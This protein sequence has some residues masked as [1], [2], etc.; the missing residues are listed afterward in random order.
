M[1]RAAVWFR[2]DLRL[3]HN[4]A[5]ARA[6]SEHDEVVAVFVLDEVLLGSAGSIKRDQL[7]AHLAGLNDALEGGLSLC[8][9]ARARRLFESVDAVHLN[10]DV[11]P[12]GARRDREMLHGLTT[13]VE[14]QFGALVQPPGAVLTQ[15]GTI[16]QVFT[17]FYKQWNR[18]PVPEMPAAGAARLA[19][20]D[21]T[22]AMPAASAPPRQPG[23]PGA[24]L[25][26]LLAW[27]ECVDDYPDTRDIPSI[28][29]TSDLSADLH[30]GTLGPTQILD[31]IDA[32]TPGREGF[33]RQ[34]AWR[35]WYAH[36]LHEHPHMVDRALKPQYD[37]IVWRD[38]DEAFAAWKAGL[39]GYPIVDAGMRQLA[40]TGWMH[41]RVRMIV[42][43]FLVKHLL[44]DWRRGERYF[45]HQLVDGDVAQNA[46]NWQWVAGTGADA[47]PYF[48][49]FNPM[50][51]S[52]K[53]DP[54][55]DYIREFVPELG[56][57]SSADIHA[58]WEAG[59]LELA[60]AGVVLGDTYPAPIVDHRMARERALATYKSALR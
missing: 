57:L 52:A 32:S 60:A 31:L 17:P 3:D 11:T 51:Q 48:R 4:P 23:G 6:T 20:I 55:G 1:T 14:Q 59:P 42:G 24:A 46:G 7:L 49:V 47:A 37:T 28:P 58:P 45:R 41:N 34:L 9:P 15:K 39:T 13:P 43:S 56:S 38:D 53:F 8:T 19:E 44:I 29:G 54:R 21:A 5:W 26:R 22:S 18:V 33:L 40:Q 50:T 10:T 16:S 27:V 12:Y 30:F 36:L 35:D 2:R 25:D